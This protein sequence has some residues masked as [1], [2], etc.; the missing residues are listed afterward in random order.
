[1]HHVNCLM[2][3]AKRGLCYQTMQSH[4]YHIPMVLGQ[5]SMPVYPCLATSGT[6]L[7]S[8]WLV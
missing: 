5:S 4:A 1:M 7:S 6:A 3:V 2:P 8:I